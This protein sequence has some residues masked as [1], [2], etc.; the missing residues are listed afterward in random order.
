VVR[1][2]VLRLAGAVPRVNRAR[3]LLA[4]A[5]VVLAIAGHRARRAG[6]WVVS[7]WFLGVLALPAFVQAPNPRYGDPGLPLGILLAFFALSALMARLGR[8]LRIRPAAL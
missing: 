4:L 6:W 8:R 1:L 5:G 7:G 2:G 3:C